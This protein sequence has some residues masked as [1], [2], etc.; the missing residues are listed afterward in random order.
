M[1]DDVAGTVAMTCSNV[2]VLELKA[3]PVCQ[4]T[5]MHAPPPIN[6][7]KKDRDGQL[8]LSSFYSYQKTLC[9]HVSCTWGRNR[10]RCLLNVGNGG[11][12]PRPGNIAPHNIS[13]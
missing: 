3:V 10:N 6:C 5:V 9:G 7:T 11:R 12:G 1:T 2:S 13:R 8:I 4:C